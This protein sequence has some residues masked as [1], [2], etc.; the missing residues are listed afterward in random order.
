MPATYEI[1]STQTLGSAA[2]SVTL[3]SIPQTYTDLVLVAQMQNTGS[4]QRIELQFNADTG[5]NYSVTRI[6]GNGT[7][8]STDRFSSVS[9]IDVAFVST[10]GF[11]IANHSIM[12]YSNTTTYKSL[13]GRWDSE[14]NSGYATA[15]V[16]LWRSTAAITSMVLTPNGVNFATGS[17]FT[18]YGIK[19]A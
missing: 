17:K 13:V 14:G 3:S 12:N 8:A 15:L 2:A 18:L 11:C 19:A 6:Y 7:T 5:S 16:G 1:I 4:A 10:S 9:H